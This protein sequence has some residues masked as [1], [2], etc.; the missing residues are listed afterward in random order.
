M[1]PIRREDARTR[2]DA[3][4]RRRRFLAL[5]SL[6]ALHGSLFLPGCARPQR[7]PT[8]E[9][10]GQVTYDGEPL[11]QGVVIF[12]PAT[13]RAASGQIRPDGS[14]TLGTYEKADGAVLGRHRAAVIAREEVAEESP[15]APLAPRVGRSLI[16]ETYGDTATSGLEFEVVAEGN[17][18]EIRLS[19][20]PPREGR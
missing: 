5:V 13:G 14:F 7:L 1:K 18:F 4:H 6:F 8:A 20:V 2:A 3:S 15:G 11:P 17:H 16:P 19:R 12:E 10:T 9:V